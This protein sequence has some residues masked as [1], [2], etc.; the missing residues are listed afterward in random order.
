MESLWVPHAF[1]EE[2]MF[3]FEQKYISKHNTFLFKGQMSLRLT[4]EVL[5][6]MHMSS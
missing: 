3:V 6:K 1:D 2:N 5:K 4:A